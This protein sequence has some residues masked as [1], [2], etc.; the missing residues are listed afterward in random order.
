MEQDCLSSGY[1]GGLGARCAAGAGWGW[2]RRIAVTGTAVV[3]ASAMASEPRPSRML[4]PEIARQF[5]PASLVD[6]GD[7]PLWRPGA[8]RG[9]RSRIRLT[10]AGRVMIRIDERASGQ[11][12]GHLIQLTRAGE[13]EPLERSV[14]GFRVTR[15]EHDLLRQ[16]VQQ[17]GLWN[18]H[19]QFY[20]SDAICI[21][22]I[23]LIF[24]RVDA[25]GYRFSTVNAQCDATV[26]L[27]RV[28]E[29]IVDISGEP[30]FRDWLH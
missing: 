30:R 7:P 23:R 8:G 4:P 13:R 28:A 26:E 5:S 16:A 27:I 14:Q 24:E 18:I 29:T 11:I 19:P 17:A 10:I 3:A 15:A 2:L 22:G 12:S 1:Q 25:N 21:D 9:Y 6:F 20:Y